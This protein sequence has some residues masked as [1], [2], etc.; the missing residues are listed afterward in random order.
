M[1]FGTCNVRSVYR[2]GSLIT[3]T[4]ELARYML[5]LVSLQEVKWGKVGA[6]RAKG[7]SF[8]MKNETKIMNWE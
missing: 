3:A 7:Y 5:D 1:R 4:M 2:A 6:V 8:S